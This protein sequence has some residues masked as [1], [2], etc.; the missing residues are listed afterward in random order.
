MVAR[1]YERYCKSDHGPYL[2]VAPDDIYWEGLKLRDPRGNAPYYLD[3]RSGADL[4][5]YAQ[6]RSVAD[7]PHPPMRPSGRL[8][9]G[10]L[11]GRQG[12]YAEYRAGWCYLDCRKLTIRGKQFRFPW[13]Q[14]KPSNQMQVEEVD[15]QANGDGAAP[16]GS[17]GAQNGG[18]AAP[19]DANAMQSGGSGSGFGRGGKANVEANTPNQP[20]MQLTQPITAAL[21]TGPAVGA[22]YAVPG[23][24]YRVDLCGNFV[25]VTPGP[26][27]PQ[28]FHL[29]GAEQGGGQQPAV[30]PP[31]MNPERQARMLSAG[32]QNC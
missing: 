25:P 16:I 3:Y 5:V 1:G 18:G 13:E 24:L 31:Y 21:Q 15:I 12:G 26:S 6:L 4:K 20:L 28:D 22:G 9:S 2:E 7:R 8:N 11:G 23:C 27:L 17:G 29:G 10:Q 14:V 19:V 30:N 32:V